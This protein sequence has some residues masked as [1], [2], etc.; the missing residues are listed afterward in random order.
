MIIVSLIEA[1]TPRLELICRVLDFEADRFLAH[2][3]AQI[4]QHL[5]ADTVVSIERIHREVLDKGE[6]SEFPYRDKRFDRP[7][8]SV[9]RVDRVVGVLQQRL[10]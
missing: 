4:G 2:E 5:G 8:V 10:L 7:F 6:G 3:L 9:A 1:D